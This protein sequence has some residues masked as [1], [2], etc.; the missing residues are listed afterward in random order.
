MSAA[1]VPFGRLR[2]EGARTFDGDREIL[3]RGVNLQ[4]RL[5]TGCARPRAW[6]AAVLDALPNMTAVRLVVL[7]WDDVRL[8]GARTLKP[9]I[10]LV[11]SLRVRDAPCSE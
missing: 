1:L 8:R 5:G 3:L 10:A 7:H 4:F 2:V 6:D 9:T 11:Q